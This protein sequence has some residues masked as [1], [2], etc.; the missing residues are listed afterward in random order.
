MAI[1]DVILSLI[2]SPAPRTLLTGNQQSAERSIISRPFLH[3]I[4]VAKGRMIFICPSQQQSSKCVWWW[5]SEI[6]MMRGSK[7]NIIPQ[8]VSFNTI[9]QSKMYTPSYNTQEWC[10]THL[11]FKKYHSIPG[12]HTP[13]R[14]CHII[15]NQTEI[16][17][18]KVNN[19]LQAVVRQRA[20]T[21][22]SWWQWKNWRTLA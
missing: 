12:I 5:C 22:I 19:S 1:M 8:D 15:A 17:E 2:V 11:Q 16:L 21:P 6:F 10:P 3:H 13:W 14:F 7:H 9:I 20:F 18:Q 4:I